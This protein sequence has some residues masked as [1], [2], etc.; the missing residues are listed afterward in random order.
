MQASCVI[1]NS[2]SCSRLQL[3]SYD[4][5]MINWNIDN[6]LLQAQNHNLV[7]T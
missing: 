6:V 4:E 1:N 5:C 2:I 3:G 7:S